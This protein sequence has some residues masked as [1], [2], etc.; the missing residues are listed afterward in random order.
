MS[1]MPSP[2][3]STSLIYEKKLGLFKYQLPYEIYTLHLKEQRSMKVQGCRP[4]S[5]RNATTQSQQKRL[6][7]EDVGIMESSIPDI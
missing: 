5:C 1:S 4:Q 3:P 6:H 2:D 7:E